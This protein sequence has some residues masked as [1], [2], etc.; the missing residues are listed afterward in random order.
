MA[1]F[2]LGGYSDT[3]ARNAHWG[4]PVCPVMQGGGFPIGTV[5]F[6][7]VSVEMMLRSLENARRMLRNCVKRLFGELGV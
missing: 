1:G 6:Q 7:Q 3:R 5:D 2:L 4:C